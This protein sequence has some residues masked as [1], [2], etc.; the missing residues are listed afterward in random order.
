MFVIAAVQL[1]APV[2][3]MVL[4][5]KHVVAG[6]KS[7]SIA[8]VARI[9]RLSGGGLIAHGTAISPSPAYDPGRLENHPLPAWN[10]PSFHAHAVDLSVDPDTG[11]V[12]IHRYVVAQDVGFAINPTYIEGQIEG[13]VAQG[14]G[15]A[16]TEEIVYREG[17]VLNP[18]LT[19]YKMPTALTPEIESI[20]VECAS[21]AGPWSH[22]RRRT[23]LYRAAG[24]IANAIAAATG[25]LAGIVA[26]DRREDRP[27]NCGPAGSDPRRSHDARQ[28]AALPARGYGLRAARVAGG[29]DG[30]GRDRAAE[31]AARHLGRLDRRRRGAAVDAAARRGC[32]RL[33]SAS[34]GGLGAGPAQEAGRD[35]RGHTSR[36]GCA[37]PVTL[38]Q[39]PQDEAYDPG[40]GGGH[41]DP[42]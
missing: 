19:D 30:G 13:G 28:P 9:S 31:R 20:L 21:V 6:D 12:D 39:A 10:T 38:P 1:D 15:Q 40:R 8:E 2:E 42:P 3:A 22:G 37:T 41:D 14:I 23:A 32:D 7:I 11:T 26:D 16:L 29:H 35:S 34:R 24:G 25:F 27:R 5:D 17:R 18:N 33:L 36:G 4:R